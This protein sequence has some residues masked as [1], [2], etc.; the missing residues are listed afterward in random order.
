MIRQETGMTQEAFAEFFYI[1]VRTIQ[2]WESESNAKRK[3]PTYLIELMLYK[4]RK[5][6]KL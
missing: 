4:L 2:N 5:E 3:P 1:P 6:N